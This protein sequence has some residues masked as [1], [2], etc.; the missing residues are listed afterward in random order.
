MEKFKG[1]YIS[2]MTLAFMWAR[3]GDPAQAINWLEVGERDNMPDLTYLA[4]DPLFASLH[5][6]PRYQAL[7][8]RVAPH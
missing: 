5:K 6:E 3:V 8:A 1:K 2:P 4:V 7:V